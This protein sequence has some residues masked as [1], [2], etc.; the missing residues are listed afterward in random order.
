MKNKLYFF[1]SSRRRHTRCALVTG[2]QT[3]ALP[4]CLKIVI[5]CANGAAYQVAPSALWELGA[6]IVAIGVSPDGLNVNDGCGS[7]APSSCQETVVASGADIG[8]AL[9]GDADRLIIVDEKGKVV[10]GDQ[11]MALIGSSWAKAG[12]LR[13]NGQIGRA[14]V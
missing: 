4:I 1:F 2:V 11:I 5:D 9:D 14:H 7:T 8:I 13:R 10:D 6:E 12:M 3:C